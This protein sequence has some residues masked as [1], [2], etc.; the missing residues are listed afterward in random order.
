M[1][2][3][4]VTARII[5]VI[6][7]G[8]PGSIPNREGA[9]GLGGVT[10]EANAF[11]YPPHTVA[12]VGAVL[13]EAGFD[14]VA[15]DA[16]ALGYD[17][18]E[19]IDE[20]RGA[21][22]ALVGVFVS[23]ATREADRLFLATLKKRVASVPVVV[24]GPSA[25][26][27]QDDLGDADHLLV[28][29][30]EM[31]F[32][33]LADCLLQGTD[34][35]PRVVSP[36]DLGV[37]GYDAQGRLTDLDALPFPAWDLLPIERYRY[38]TVLSSRGC[39]ESCSWC[40]YVVAQGRRFRACSADRVVAELHEI[41]ERYRPQRIVFR[42]P[43][44]AFDS[45]RVEEIC[46]RII[47]DRVL[48]PGK[49]LRW[50]CESHPGHLDKRLLR[51]MSL[52]GC[53]SIKVGLETTDADLLLREHRVTAE[54]GAAEYLAHVGS[55]A[56]ECARLGIS[57]RIFAMAGLPGQTAAMAQETAGFVRA[58]R[59]ASLSVK[60]L[61]QYPG[62]R[63]SSV[64][65]PTREEVRAQIEILE[66]AQQDVGQG[67]IRRTPRWHRAILRLV[68]RLFTVLSMGRT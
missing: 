15:V 59:P 44:F 2:G 57:Y 54:D 41:V 4:Q 6:P 28:S 46:G 29:E 38:L 61:K 36:A 55:L 35:L 14:V 24:F 8:L 53:V 22:A 19:C 56:R 21:K 40:P 33:A 13:Q 31:A 48:K 11:R 9:S 47:G 10:P 1:Q 3:G 66:E 25:A 68:F 20:V 39:G 65:L 32:A 45:E 52:A 18:D 12:T 37:D 60:A 23:W 7:S 50:E 49:V 42:D 34:S 62:L 27:A 67:R 16:P 30:P 51:L 64:A 43:A 17:L 58:L 5:L 63:F 26:L